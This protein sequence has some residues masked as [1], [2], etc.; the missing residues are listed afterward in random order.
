ML[1]GGGRDRTVLLVAP[2]AGAEQQHRRER[3][4]AAIAW[5]TT[6]PAKS[7]NSTENT[8]LSQACKPKL[9]CQAMPSKKG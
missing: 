7:W 6:L 1:E 5:T 2:A 4:P 8:L 9:P 3:D